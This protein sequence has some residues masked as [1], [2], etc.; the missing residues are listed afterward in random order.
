MTNQLNRL[1]YSSSVWRNQNKKLLRPATQNIRHFFPN[2]SLSHQAATTSEHHGE[3]IPRQ[4]TE[5]ASER[6]KNTPD[7]QKRIE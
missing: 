5:S 7:P 1:C 2:A 6:S 4:M 3:I